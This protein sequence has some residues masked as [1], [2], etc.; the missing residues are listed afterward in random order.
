ML[1]SQT[2]FPGLRFQQAPAKHLP[3]TRENTGKMRPVQVA[4]VCFLATR[5]GH[6]Q[7]Q[8]RTWG[9][10]SAPVQLLLFRITDGK[11]HHSHDCFSIFHCLMLF[12]SKKPQTTTDAYF[13]VVVGEH[14]LLAKEENTKTQDVFLQT[15][16]HLKGFKAWVYFLRKGFKTKEKGKSVTKEPMN[17]G[18]RIAWFKKTRRYCTFCI[19]SK[20]FG[21]TELVLK[22]F[23]LIIMS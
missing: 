3:C 14:C 2:M 18:V 10:K 5:G 7:A 22:C 12:D 15:S 16:L 20:C 8:P 9:Y 21:F 6:P 1:K 23:L 17:L 19:S 4:S 11:V 13:F